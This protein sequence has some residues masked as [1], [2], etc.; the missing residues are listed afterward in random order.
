MA[1]PSNRA[2]SAARGYGARWQKYRAGFLFDHPLCRM[3]EAVG[4]TTPATV[5]DHVNPH[6]GDTALFWDESNHQP[7]CG[8]CH[9][10]HKQK[11]EKSGT[12]RGCDA[13]GNPIDAGHHW[14]K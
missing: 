9:N 5:V 2:S 14:N 1:N 8:T 3:C 12:L 4:R 13:S 6:R 11:L 7:L 10:A